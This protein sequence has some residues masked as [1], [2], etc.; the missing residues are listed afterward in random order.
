LLDALVARRYC[1]QAYPV[2]A[3]PTEVSYGPPG[4]TVVHFDGTRRPL[5]S[6]EDLAD[7]VTESR[8]RPMLASSQG[9]SAAR[10]AAF[11]LPGSCSSTRPASARSHPQRP[12]RRSGCQRDRAAMSCCRRTPVLRTRANTVEEPRRA[13]VSDIFRAQQDRPS[14]WR[15]VGPDAAVR[16]RRP[17]LRTSVDRRGFS[18][19]LRFLL[20]RRV[21]PKGHRA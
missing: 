21:S 12:G 4:I 16:L 2:T 19:W 15:R 1:R 11:S 7:F 13:A 9:R 20:L 18:A 8:T 3:V 10:G 6:G 17:S 5:G 14:V